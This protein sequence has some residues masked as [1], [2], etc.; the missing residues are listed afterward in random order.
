MF[1]AKLRG[2]NWGCKYRRR[3]RSLPREARA[4][5]CLL[6]MGLLRNGL[7]VKPQIGAWPGGYD[8]GTLNRGAIVLLPQG[9]GQPL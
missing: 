8:D 7:V 9:M 3:N 2:F 1:A 6:T 4:N 5:T